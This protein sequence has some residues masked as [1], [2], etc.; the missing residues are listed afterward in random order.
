MLVRT[1]KNVSWD[2]GLDLEGDHDLLEVRH[3]H[4]HVLL[5]PAFEQ[6]IFQGLQVRLYNR[7]A[8]LCLVVRLLHR[9]VAPR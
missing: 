1:Q 7:V 3:V 9:G 8:C 4:R 5:V 2:F 6:R